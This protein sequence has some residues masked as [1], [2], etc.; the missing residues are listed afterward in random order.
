M[1]DEP[2]KFSNEAKIRRQMSKRG[3]TEQQVREAIA[4]PGIPTSGKLG[5]ATRHVHPIS[6]KSIVVDDATGEIFH[7]GGKGFLYE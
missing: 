3:W 6:G 1:A 7:V 2:L 4:T 5:P